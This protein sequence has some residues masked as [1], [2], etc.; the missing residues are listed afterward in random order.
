MRNNRIQCNKNGN[1]LRFFKQKQALIL[2][3]GLVFIVGFLLFLASARGEEY[4]EIKIFP[5]AFQGDWQNPEAVFSQDLGENAEFQQFNKDNSAYPIL[6][7]ITKQKTA[8][9]SGFSGISNVMQNSGLPSYFHYS[10]PK[11]L[12]K[13]SSIT[14]NKKSL[15]VGGIAPPD[16]WM[17][18]PSPHYV[19][20]RASLLYQIFQRFQKIKNFIKSAAT[21]V[22]AAITPDF[23]GAQEDPDDFTTPPQDGISAPQ[24]ASEPSPSPEET[25]TSTPTPTPTIEPTP[26]QTSLTGHYGESPT[27]TPE[28]TPEPTVEPII[29]PE[30]TLSPEPTIT[31]EP[32]PNIQYPISNIQ[33]PVEKVLELSKFSL[34]KDFVKDKKI[35]IIQ[36]RFSLAAKMR[37]TDAKLPEGTPRET[38]AKLLIEYYYQS[39]WQS[40]ASFDLENEI[41]NSLNG[42]YFLYGLPIFENWSDLENLKIRFTYIANQETLSNKKPAFEADSSESR[43]NP[44]ILGLSPTSI[45]ANQD[46]LSSPLGDFKGWTRGELHPGDSRRQPEISDYPGPTQDLLYQSKAPGQSILQKIK[47]LFAARA[48]ENISRNFAPAPLDNSL[49]NGVNFAS[50]SPS[51]EA[52]QVSRSFAVY[53]DALWLEVDYE[54]IS[55]I[56]YPISKIEKKDFRSDEEPEFELPERAGQAGLIG[57]MKQKIKA[58][59]Q[60]QMKID[61][62]S[63]LGPEGEEI[64]WEFVFDENKTG[65]PIVRI[66]KPLNFRPGKYS[67]KIEIEKEGKI[68]NLEQ[69]FTWGVLAINTNK[70]IYLPQETAY[71]QMAALRDDGHTICDAKLRL[72]IRNPKSEILNLSTEDGTIKYSG[73]CGPDNVTDAPDYFAY[74]QIAGPGIYQMKLTNLNNGYEITDSFEVRESV[75]FDVERIGPT[76]IYPPVSYEMKMMVKANQDFVGKVIET[77]PVSFEIIEANPREYQANF[78]ESSRFDSRQFASIIGQGET[79]QIIWNV[80]WLAGEEYELRYQFDAPDISPYLYLLG[81]LEFYQ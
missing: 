23:A 57:G 39:T 66:R 67:L 60:K 3:L 30:P 69:E 78:R 70:S 71:L 62:V 64:G 81:P 58:V 52:A 51:G 49:S 5:T 38:D 25:P 29:T 54:E 45:I 34:P 53:L 12:V 6:L 63:F 17:A 68:Y 50:V 76:R 42:G 73:K 28:A 43:D 19:T 13:R 77:V 72:E 79:K 11:N 26:K 9:I 40:L 47:N 10:R 20:P 61:E 35:E 24:S 37:E 4:K 46:T 41:S 74:Y 27:P 2:I 15:E 75:P 48:Q 18:I 56:Q 55:N 8:E 7:N 44:M 22:I 1:M 80:T 33:K 59:F 14:E 65:N 32:T 16:S 21:T 36:L 31:P